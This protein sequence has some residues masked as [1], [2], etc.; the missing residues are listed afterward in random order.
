MFHFLPLHASDTPKT[1]THDRWVAY[2]RRH[3]E[4]IYSI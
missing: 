4:T 1:Q 3:I 2:L